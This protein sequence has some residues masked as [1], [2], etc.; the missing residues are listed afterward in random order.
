MVTAGVGER[1]PQPTTVIVDVRVFDGDVVSGPT[2]VT[3]ADAVIVGVGSAATSDPQLVVD[4]GG[5]VLLA[6]SST[7]TSTSAREKPCSCTAA[8]G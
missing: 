4:G 8:G 1:A 2:T 5:G 7:P 6:G 3:L